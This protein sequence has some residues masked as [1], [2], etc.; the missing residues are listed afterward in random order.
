MTDAE[1]QLMDRAGRLLA[2]RA[3][4]RTELEQ[5]LLHPGANRPEPD[6][7][8]VKNVLDRLEALNILNDADFAAAYAGELHRKG[9][10]YRYAYAK[11]RSHG[12]E[13]TLAV[14]AL[15]GFEWKG[16]GSDA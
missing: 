1:K 8:A 7:S 15:Q 12:I 4:S 9:K 11:L 16:D 2:R 13:H 3:H 10:P 6:L 5:K 14:E